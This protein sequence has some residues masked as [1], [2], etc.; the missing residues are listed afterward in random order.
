M[1]GYIVNLDTPTSLKM[2]VDNGVYATKL[3]PPRGYWMPHHEGTF[4]DFVTMKPGD[5][6]Y[7][8][9]KRKIY[10]IGELVNITDEHRN[11]SDCCYLNF[12]N[13]NLPIEFPYATVS[14]QLLWDEGPESTNQ[15]WVCFF[16]PCPYFFKN[17]I[18]MDDVLAS[19]PAQFRML[20]V[21]WKV[22][23][24][25]IDDDEN[26]ALKEVIL[27][28][29]ENVLTNPDDAVFPSCYKH[30]HLA[31][32]SQLNPSYLLEPSKILL[33]CSRG[34][35]VTHEMALEA[36]LLYQL[37]KKEPYTTQ[38]FGKW[39]YLSHQVVASPFKPIDY[40]DKMDIFGYAYIPGFQPA[41]SRYLVIEIKRSTAARDDIEQIMKYVDWVKDEYCSGDY[42]MI[43]AFV[44]AYEFPNDVIRHAEKI[45]RRTY[46]IGRRPARSGEWTH[47]KLVKYS[48]DRN[49]CLLRFH[50]IPI[51]SSTP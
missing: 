48:F 40:M 47:L 37:H 15:R 32:K 39:D 12:P 43:R 1:A 41:K 50:E 26:Q 17:G 44:V 45:G 27:R 46:T 29:N 22:S 33:E 38:I 25:K 21:F 9:I 18:D 34:D 42:S 30:F 8:F 49:N 24:I 7:F 5:N 11:L 4:A 6:I 20:R 13:A 10:G 51:F 19:N 2:Y 23:F 3:R 31:I 28:L 35:L 36:G 16:K 14:D